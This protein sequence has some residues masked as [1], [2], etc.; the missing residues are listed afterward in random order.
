MR[1]AFTALGGVDAWVNNAGADVLTGEAAAWERER[2]LDLL[3]DVDLRGTMRCSWDAGARM[4]EQPGGGAIVNVGWDQ[5]STGM[6]GEKPEL[7]A[8]VKAGVLGFSRSLARTLAPAVRVNVVAPGWISTA[9]GDD[10]PA[11]LRAEVEAATPLGRWGTPEDVAGAVRWLASPEAA[12]VTGQVVN[13][14][15]GLVT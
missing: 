8:A 10:A 14:N 4:R 2:K 9:F 11:R 1:E 6:A 7:F 3:L 15:G 5:A 12:F 13:V